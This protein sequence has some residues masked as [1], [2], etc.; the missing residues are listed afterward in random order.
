MNNE[1][2]FFEEISNDN[3]PHLLY[4]NYILIIAP[5]PILTYSSLFFSRFLNCILSGWKKSSTDPI[6]PFLCF[7]IRISA[8]FFLSVSGS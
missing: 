5:S 2:V 6:G 4:E 3:P 7:R 8:I 1:D